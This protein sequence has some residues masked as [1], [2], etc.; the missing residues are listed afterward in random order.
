MFNVSWFNASN[1]HIAVH[2]RHGDSWK[3]KHHP[4]IPVKQYADAIHEASLQIQPHL[5]SVYIASDDKEVGHQVKALLDSTTTT[6]K[7]INRGNYTVYFAFTLTS[8]KREYNKEDGQI[9]LLADF[10]A[11]CS[12]TFFIGTQTSNMGRT[13]FYVRGRNNASLSRSLDGKW[14]EWEWT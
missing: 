4:S 6:E 3:E 14:T 2:I 7:P 10:E 9:A 12:A 13:A 11:M 5:R 8:K 1:R